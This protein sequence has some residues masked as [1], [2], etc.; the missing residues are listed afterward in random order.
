MKACA[1]VLVLA[2]SSPAVARDPAGSLTPAFPAQG[3]PAAGAKQ[4][5]AIQ[6]EMIGTGPQV[7]RKAFAQL[8]AYIASL[9][10]EGTID[11]YIVHGRG[12]E[13]GQLFC[14]QVSPFRASAAQ[15][16]MERLDRITV[17]PATTAYNRHFIEECRVR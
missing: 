9:V 5:R 14:L 13:G 12:I 17:D 7:D 3:S 10:A 11:R 4:G 2:M 15:A 8:M 16:I 6:I 1:L